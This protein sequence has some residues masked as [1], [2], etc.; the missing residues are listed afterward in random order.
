MNKFKSLLI[1]MRPQQ[2]TKN[3]LVFAAL[4]FS[5]N[6]LNIDAFITVFLT[7][8]CFCLTS[9]VIYIVNDWKDRENDRIHPGKKNRPLACGAIS[10][11]DAFTF[12]VFIVIADIIILFSLGSHVWMVLGAY[13][14]MNIAYTFKLKHVVILDIIIVALGFVLRA[15]S[16]GVVIEVEI[17]SWLIVAT[18][19]LA[20]FLVLCKRRFEMM[21][22]GKNAINHRKNLSDYSVQL[23]DQMIAIVSGITILSYSLYTLSPQT[24]RKFNTE[25][26]ILTIPFVVFGI[27]KYLHLIYK[28]QL[29]G[30]PE[31]IL[32]N[33]RYIQLSIILWIIC[34]VVIIY[35]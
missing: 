5:N 26:L 35:K 1:L 21:S 16:G 13:F 18:F 27:F 34:A 32:L 20:L 30:K 31:E 3:L 11:G 4:I 19:F 10:T 7:F 15:I 22:L 8:C 9:S 6:L 12:A 17:S 23:L 14:L 28:K 33:D 25:N 24:I 2:W 29:G